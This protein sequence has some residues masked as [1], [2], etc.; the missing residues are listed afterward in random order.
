VTLAK[1]PILRALETFRDIE[2]MHADAVP[3]DSLLYQFRADGEQRHLFLCNT[4]RERGR[5]NTAIRLRGRWQPMQR[6]TLTGDTR[7]ISAWLAGDDTIVP[8]TFRPHDH[9]L[10][11]LT[12]GDPPTTVALPAERKWRVVAHLHGPVP[13]TLSEPNVLLLD[14]ASWR[15]DGG[16]WREREEILRLDNLVR[17]KLNLSLRGGRM[18][19]PWTDQEPAPALAE[20]ELKFIIRSDIDVPAA[21]LAIED[22]ETLEIRLDGQLVSRDITGWWVDEAFKTISLPPITR[23][24]HELTITIPFTRKTNVEA[25]YLLGDFGVAVSGRDA[26]ITAPVRELAFGDWMH[27]GLPFYGGNVTYHCVVH[28]DTAGD[29]VQLECAK[30]KNPLLSVDLDGRPAGKV[31]FAPFHLDLGPLAPGEHRIDITAFGSRVN[32]FGALHNANDKLT[33]IGPA[34]WRQTGGNFSYEYQFKRTGILAAP[35]VRAAAR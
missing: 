34:A 30:F 32:T 31:A 7:P 23:G 11:T 20:L 4:D 27:Q 33:W 15:L 3:A 8:W 19:Q 13:V 18:A 29:D 6:D 26:R 12:P 25:C 5:W 22:A 1:Q 17:A 35:I 9:L 24:E 28:G 14:Q 16:E 10:L 2:V 21:Q